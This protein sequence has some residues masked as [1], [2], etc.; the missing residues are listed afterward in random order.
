VTGKTFGKLVVR[1]WAEARAV[2]GCQPNAV[3]LTWDF[4]DYPH[5][6]TPRGFGV[7]FHHG[8][9][10]CHLRFARKLLKQ[11]PARIDGVLRHE[12]GHVI[13]LVFDANEVTGWAN[14]LGVRLA[15]PN[16]AERRADDIAQV[17][18]G[19]PILYDT[20]LWVQNTQHGVAPRPKH[21][22]W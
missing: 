15:P 8:G 5:F 2:L 21:L 17:V 19:A 20:A 10:V 18:W 6:E 22:G 16:Q 12:I 9:P 4:G 14:N 1:R 7:T 3:T 11:E 13:D